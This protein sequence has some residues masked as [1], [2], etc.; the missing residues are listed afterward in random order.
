VKRRHGCWLRHTRGTHTHTHTHTHAL[1]TL[2]P[3]RH[4]SKGLAL[5]YSDS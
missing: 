5:I 3:E 1:H 2:T 4:S